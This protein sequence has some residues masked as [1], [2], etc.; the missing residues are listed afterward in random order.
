MNITSIQLT[1]LNDPYLIK[2]QMPQCTWSN[3]ERYSPFSSTSDTKYESLD[4]EI[5]LKI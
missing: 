3:F 2:T 5:H 1:N 4:N